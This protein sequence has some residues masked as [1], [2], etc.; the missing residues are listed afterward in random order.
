MNE[1]MIHVERI[2]RPIRGDSSKLRMRREL[3]A[4]LQASF[5]QERSRGSDEVAAIAEAKRRLGVPAVLTQELQASVP[6]LERL[7]AT[8]FPKFVPIALVVI[9]V[10]GPAIL[11]MMPVHG[12]PV[13]HARWVFVAGIAVMELDF[14]LWYVFVR[15]IL[16]PRTRWGRTYLI[17][18]TAFV[19]QFAWLSPV[20]L[21]L[22]GKPM[23]AEFSSHAIEYLIP[24][25]AYLLFGPAMAATK[26]PLK[27]WHAIE[28]AD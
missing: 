2:V 28:I 18:G 22:T 5:E 1:F 7:A 8:P 15:A 21:G 23:L 11:A 17:G 26:L 14:L 9:C 6:A 19:L 13:L 4:H 27:Q 10:L 3:L 24:S 16:H 25:I 12:I 20:T